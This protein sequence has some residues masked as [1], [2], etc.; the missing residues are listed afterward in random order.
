[1]SIAIN[2]FGKIFIA[3]LL[4]AVRVFVRRLRIYNSISTLIAI[5]IERREGYRRKTGLIIQCLLGI[6]GLIRFSWQFC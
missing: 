6:S 3:F 5:F 4:S 1:M 2:R